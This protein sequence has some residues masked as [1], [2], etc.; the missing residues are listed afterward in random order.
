[1]ASADPTSCVTVCGG[2]EWVGRAEGSLPDPLSVAFRL[3]PSL[4]SDRADRVIT[5]P[6]A[7]LMCSSLAAWI[8]TIFTTDSLNEP[9]QLGMSFQRQ[10][11]WKMQPYFSGHRTQEALC[12]YQYVFACLTK[13][14]QTQ[15]KRLIQMIGF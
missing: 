4:G 2:G 14:D 15:V 3:Q 7:G 1:M 11:L 10:L 13:T 5:L 9:A 6:W 12:K 8:N